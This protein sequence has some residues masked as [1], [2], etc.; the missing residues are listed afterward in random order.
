[1]VMALT[2]AQPQPLTNTDNHWHCPQDVTFT[3]AG[4]LDKRRDFFGFIAV[5][6]RVDRRACYLFELLKGKGEAV[7][8]VGRLHLPCQFT[9]YHA[10]P[11]LRLLPEPLTPMQ[12]RTK[13]AKRPSFPPRLR[14]SVGLVFHQSWMPYRLADL[15]HRRG[16]L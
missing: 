13:A 10:M 1:M 9:A 2:W 15:W 6:V 12:K 11:T 7:C 8:K 14:R 16:A 4:I 3:T 5:D